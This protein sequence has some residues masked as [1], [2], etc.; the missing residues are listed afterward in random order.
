MFVRFRLL[1]SCVLLFTAQAAAAQS[2]PAEL[3]RDADARACKPVLDTSAFPGLDLPLF[4]ATERTEASAIYWCTRG[5]S[6]AQT[7]LIVLR[8]PQGCPVE[9]PYWNPP[10]GL[11][12]EPPMRV[13][14]SEFRPVLQPELRGPDVS[15][16]AP[17]VRAEYDGAG[18][19]FVCHD[20]KWYVAHFH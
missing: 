11:T 12:L 10:G 8:P 18:G 4:L 16:T 14:L 17:S 6:D 15:V 2:F 19:I 3:Q 9:I 5:V 1:L 13:R 20:G 7:F